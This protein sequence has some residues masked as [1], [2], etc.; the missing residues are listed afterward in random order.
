M[1]RTVKIISWA[2]YD[3]ANQFF[4]LNVVSLYFVRWLTLEKGAPEILYSVF[5]G[6]STLFVAL[7]APVLGAFSDAAGRR[8]PFLIYCTLLSILFTML[9]GLADNIFLGL[10]FFAVANFGC[11]MG[12]VFYN[13]MLADIA[14]RRKLG[15]ISGLGRMFGYSG[16]IIT[17]FIAKPIILKSGY[18]AVFLPTGFF[19]LLFS[20]PCLIFVKD[21]HPAPAGIVLPQFF[22]KKSI[23][24]FFNNIKSIIFSSGEFP[25]LSNFLKASFFGLCGIN[26]A[27]LFMSVYATRVFGLNEAQIINLVAFSAFFAVAGSFISGLVSDYLGHRRTLL[28][29]FILWIICFSCGAFARNSTLYLVIGGL[30]GLTLGATWTVARALAIRIAPPERLGEVFGLFNFAGYLAAITGPLFWGLV[31]LIA[32]S[33]GTKGYRIALLSLNLFMFLGVWFLLRMPK[34]DKNK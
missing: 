29:V 23:F 26:A 15:L 4:A 5:F 20:L 14:P 12:V 7:F 6:I 3:L 33:F 32:G 1:K 18:Q 21:A 31:L 25:L 17:L 19:F 22:N 10:L 27:L 11:Q 13:A 28:A 30:L 9:L 16:A 8:R 24:I 2:L 34:I